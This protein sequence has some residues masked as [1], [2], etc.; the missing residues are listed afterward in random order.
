MIKVYEREV[1]K[2][3]ISWLRVRAITRRLVYA[4]LPWR[5]RLFLREKATFSR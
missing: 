1:G 4:W 5:L 2:R 3:W